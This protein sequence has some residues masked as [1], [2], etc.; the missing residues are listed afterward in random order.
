MRV[1]ILIE[2]REKKN[3]NE[4]TEKRTKTKRQSFFNVRTTK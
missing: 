4:K 2:R 1:L 3:L